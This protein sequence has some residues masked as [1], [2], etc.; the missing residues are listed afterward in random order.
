MT[1][2]HNLEAADRTLCDF[3]QPV[4][5][6]GR[7][8]VLTVANLLQMLPVL[9]PITGSQITSACFKKSRLYSLFKSLHLHSQI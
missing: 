2:R 3:F 8:L 1:H 7:I 5:P 6:F 4:L 9:R